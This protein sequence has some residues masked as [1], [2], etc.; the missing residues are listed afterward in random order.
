M[1]IRQERLLLLNFSQVF[2]NGQYTAANDG[3]GIAGKIENG[4]R[5]ILLLL[6]LLLLAQ[7]FLG[8]LAGPS[9]GRFLRN[10]RCSMPASPDRHIDATVRCR[11][12][13]SVNLLV[14]GALRKHAFV[15]LGE[16]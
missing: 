14:N 8:A 5:S 10:R 1:A 4:C 11:R 15:P 3:F 16:D 12:L 7:A 2:N 6:L 13:S 9:P